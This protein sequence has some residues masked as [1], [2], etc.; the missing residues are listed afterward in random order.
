MYVQC[1]LMR[2]VNSTRFN[3]LSFTRITIQYNEL[4]NEKYKID[5][6]ITLL[7]LFVKLQTIKC[8]ING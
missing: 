6:Y 8:F 2:T 4:Y 5:K 7:F 1:G 3:G